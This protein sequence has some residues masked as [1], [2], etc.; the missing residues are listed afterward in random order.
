VPEPRIPIANIY[1]MFCY[2]WDRFEQAK[3]TS[4]GAEASPD[5]PNLLGRVLLGGVRH[6]LRRGLDR[7]YQ[8]TVEE[9]ATVRGRIGLNATLLLR[10]QHVR[11]LSCEFDDLSH[12]VVHNRIVKATMLR[13]AGVKGLERDLAHELRAM[14]RTLADVRDARLARSE[15]AR[16]QLHRNNAYYDFLLRVCRLAFDLMLPTS[17][18][19]GYQFEDVLRDERKMALVFEAFV[20]NFYR[21]EQKL[22]RVAPLQL[23]WDA[24]PLSVD[25]AAGLPQMRT[26]IFL[27]SPSRHIIIDTKYYAEALQERFGTSTFRSE[28]LYQLFAY[29]KNAE[30]RGPDFASAEGMLLY[31]ATGERIDARYRMQGHDVRIATVNLDQDWRDIRAELLA[32]IAPVPQEAAA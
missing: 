21:S 11:R 16:V 14:S 1:Y 9:L 29:L 10:A 24:T 27:T 31:P 12:D 6:L 4:V 26:D 32:L 5:L 22:F 20:R 25:K 3:A 17:D 23:D 28:N 8:S 7:G 15:F 18:G 30:V 13:L 2:A 19:S